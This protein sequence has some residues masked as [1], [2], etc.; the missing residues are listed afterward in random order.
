MDN[1]CNDTSDN[2]NGTSNTP[3]KRKATEP[4]G[5]HS[6]RSRG[7]QESHVRQNINHEIPPRNLR[8][9]QKAQTIT[10]RNMPI[11]AIFQ[12]IILYVIDFLTVTDRKSYVIT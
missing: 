4:G 1:R 8:T 6:K 12:N 7:D 9:L 3:K 5:N 10:L 2:N 11:P